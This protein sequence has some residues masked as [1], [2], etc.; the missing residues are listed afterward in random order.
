MPPLSPSSVGEPPTLPLGP[1]GSADE[2]LCRPDGCAGVQIT[3]KLLSQYQEVP[4]LILNQLYFLA[5]A[6]TYP[7][8]DGTDISLPCSPLAQ[9]D[10]KARCLNIPCVLRSSSSE[11]FT[12]NCSARPRSGQGV[13]YTALRLLL[14]CTCTAGGCSGPERG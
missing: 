2:S 6:Q 4:Q 11:T 13:Q 1:T 14:S 7:F 8:A 10:S 12:C 9:T 5:L 3:N